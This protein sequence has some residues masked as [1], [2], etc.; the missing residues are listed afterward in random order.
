VADPRHRLGRSGE[1]RACR[2]LRREGLRILERNW[3]HPMGELDIVARDGDVLVI[4]EVRTGR[5]D[6]AGGPLHTVGPAKQARLMRL[7]QLYLRRCRWAPRAM[8]FDIVA[9]RRLG[10]LRWEIEWL[11]D[12]L[13]T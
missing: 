3:R 6:F 4:V 5:R 10:F 2:L 8:R 7:G 11:R 1:R 9:V 13:H 12:A